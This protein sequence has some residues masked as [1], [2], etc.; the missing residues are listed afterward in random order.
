MHLLGEN[1]VTRSFALALTL[2]VVTL[3]PGGIAAQADP[4]TPAAPG[5]EP[6]SVAPAPPN[7]EPRP[8]RREEP[9]ERPPFT[10][11]P[12]GFV[13]LAYYRDL[14]PFAARD[15]AGQALSTSDGGADLLSVRGSR[16]G[17]RA[18]FRD[19]VW[20]AKLGAVIEADFKGGFV[21]SLFTT[22]TTTTT[23]CTSATPPVCTSTS[24][25][26]TTS[27][28]P[29]TAWSTPLLRFRRANLRATWSTRAGDVA[30]VAGQEKTLLAP[31]APATLAYGGTQLF[32]Y[33]GNLNRRSPLF[34]IAYEGRG[35]VGVDAAAA[36]A[37]PTD[38][39]TPVDL[40]NGN[41]ARRPDVEGR[42]ALF[43]G[44]DRKKVVVIGASG[45]RNT[46]RYV[47]AGKPDVDVPEWAGALEA[48]LDVRYLTLQG[49]A[50]TG[51]AIDDTYGGIA[52]AVNSTR[53]YAS[54]RT[55]G[56]WGQAIVKPAALVDLLAGYGIEQPRLPDLADV[57][58]RT[59]NT[60]YGGGVIVNAHEV[61]RLG[62]ESYRTVSYT[63]DAG[64]TVSRAAA[65]QIILAT[66]LDF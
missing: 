21:P 54:V 45:H 64:G 18:A 26:N 12:Y 40:G 31:L 28:A 7:D 38:A 36:I 53:S 16:V 63:Q 61:W 3:T 33:A 59:K 34:E 66:R 8:P 22:T 60:M 42:L 10:F 65:V 43:A 39:G 35:A 14:G 27:A 24:T 47:S 41:R 19:E 29:S 49:E 48:V 25:S 46:R 30:L 58:A 2:W 51:S 32:A 44:T 13:H 11:T 23:T 15:Y 20:G 17:L 5:D 4:T 50:F 56:A 37:S 55:A 52:P 6:A 1:A 57:A 9:K 62:V